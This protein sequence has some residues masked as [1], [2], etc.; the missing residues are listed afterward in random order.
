[1][2]TDESKHT[3]G[4]WSAKRLKANTVQI[5]ADYHI[6]QMLFTGYPGAVEAN[7]HLIAAAPTMYEALAK[8]E[9]DA[10]RIVS[11]AK[12]G[13]DLWMHKWKLAYAQAQ[14]VLHALAKARGES[15]ESEES[16]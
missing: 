14:A 8:L 11:D 7:A 13:G 3:P 16:K 12:N 6:C 1:M 15:I 10:S 9:A 5:V 4:P 2:K